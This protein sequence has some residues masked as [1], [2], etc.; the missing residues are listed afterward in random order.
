MNKLGIWGIAIAGAFVVGILSANPVVEAVGGWK[1]AFAGLDTRITALENQ[2]DPE[3]QVY[4]VSGV[5]VIPTGQVFGSEVQLRCLDGDWF[6]TTN[7]PFTL[8]PQPPPDD[9]GSIINAQ[10][11]S[12]HESDVTKIFFSKVIGKDVTPQNQGIVQPFP[13]T[14]TVVGFCVSPSP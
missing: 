10:Q 2:P 9:S 1:G 11:T 12:I 13:I 14:V 8:R 5:S 4:E 7:V 3:S 6:P